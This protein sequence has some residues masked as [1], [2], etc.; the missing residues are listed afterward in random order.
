[1]CV[2]GLTTTFNYSTFPISLTLAGSFTATQNGNVN[3]VGTL[4]GFCG[5]APGT[6]F[7]PQSCATGAP[8]GSSDVIFSGTSI[9]AIPV[10][11]GQIV[12]VTVTFTFS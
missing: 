2:T 7:S 5:T 8:S 4:L 11:S 10:T 6:T 9:T 3:Q 1:M 12:Q